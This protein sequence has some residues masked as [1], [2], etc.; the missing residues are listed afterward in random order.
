MI[1]TGS[2]GV[3]ATLPIVFGMIAAVSAIGR[4]EVPPHELV[5]IQRDVRTV[6]ARE[7]TATGFAERQA[8]VHELQSALYREV[9]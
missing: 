3:W 2:M 5:V 9:A 7:S 6:L 4:A 8:A 1:G